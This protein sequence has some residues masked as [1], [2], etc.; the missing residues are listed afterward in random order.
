MVAGETVE[1]IRRPDVLRETI[2]CR[3][4]RHFSEAHWPNSAEYRDRVRYN[5]VSQ[6]KPPILKSKSYQLDVSGEVVIAFSN[7]TFIV[8]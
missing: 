8:L 3:R 1:R 6:D 7:P 4:E 2:P 5:P